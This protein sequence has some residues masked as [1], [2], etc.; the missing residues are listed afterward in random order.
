MGRAMKIDVRSATDV[1]RVAKLVRK[2]QHIRQ[3]D[4]A[5]IIGASHVYLRDVERGKETVSI[6]GVLRLF[7]ELGIYITLD[8]PDDLNLTFKELS[9]NGSLE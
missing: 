8:V 3:D 5:S 1:G 6:G 9:E 2:K 4:L 7:D